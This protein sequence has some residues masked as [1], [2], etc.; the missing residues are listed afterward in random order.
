[1]PDTLPIR[2]DGTFRVELTR[3]EDGQVLHIPGELEL[4]GTEVILRREGDRLVIEPVKSLANFIEYLRG[5]SD[6]DDEFPEIE[7]PPP[8]PVDL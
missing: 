3:D 6:I 5:L 7:D 8:E 2:K 4:E 1:M